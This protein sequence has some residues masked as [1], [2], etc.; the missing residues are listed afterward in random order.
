MNEIIESLQK[1]TD[2]SY[3]NEDNKKNCFVCKH[4]M[5]FKHSLGMSFQ[6]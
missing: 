3:K 2:L 1:E 5:S 4:A 6:F